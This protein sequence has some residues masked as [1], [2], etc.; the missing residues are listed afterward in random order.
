MDLSN[1]EVEINPDYTMKKRINGNL[2]L[3]QEEM[4]ILKSFNVNYSMYS[5]LSDLIYELETLEE[6][7]SDDVLSNI[8]DVLSERNYYENFK[9]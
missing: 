6:E 7:V 9:K 1:L 8:I 4:D 2:Y 3:S 5:S